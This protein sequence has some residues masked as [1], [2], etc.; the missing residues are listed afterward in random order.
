MSGRVVKFLRMGRLRM[1]VSE[2]K[3]QWLNNDL[4][5]CVIQA[6]DEVWALPKV[7]VERGIHYVRKLEAAKTI[8]D[9]QKVYLEY[10]EDENRP[11]LLPA[12]VVNFLW[13]PDYLLELI[14]SVIQEDP[15]HFNLDFEEIDEAD[16][17]QLFELSKGLSFD[18]SKCTVYRDESDTLLIYGQPSLWTDEWIPAEI[19][20]KLGTTDTGYGIDYEPAEFL[21]LNL[22]DFVKEFNSYGISILLQDKELYELSGY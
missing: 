7:E 10:L 13:E 20:E 9:A 17:E 22:E 5:V 11:K 6:H 3:D 15:S 4:I 2:A 18:L 8:E 21:Y 14:E 19:A 16:V 12:N 1:S